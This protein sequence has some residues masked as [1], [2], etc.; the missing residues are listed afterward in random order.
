MSV[1][2]PSRRQRVLLL[3]LHNHQPVGN[4]DFVLEEATRCAY[5]PF[6]ETLWRFPG[7]KATLHYSGYLLR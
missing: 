7:I 1:S 2:K 6:L 3:C 4:F 5:L